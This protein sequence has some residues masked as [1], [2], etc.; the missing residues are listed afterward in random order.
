MLPCITPSSDPASMRARARQTG[1]S[2]RELKLARAA[3]ERHEGE[4]TCNGR[5]RQPR[6][7]RCRHARLALPTRPCGKPK[8]SLPRRAPVLAARLQP[9][10]GDRRPSPLFLFMLRFLNADSSGGKKKATDG[11][12][13]VQHETA[14]VGI[15]G[16]MLEFPIN[17]CPFY[18]GIPYQNV[19]WFSSSGFNSTG[20][21]SKRFLRLSAAPWRV[22][23]VLYQMCNPA[24]ERSNR[25]MG[26]GV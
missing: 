15:M 6:G 1:A 5:Q 7:L 8:Y 13:R 20:F 16:H 2:A 25:G 19:L 10:S 3:A 12:G 11:D 18:V 22:W 4:G 23:R 14:L 17:V 9:R 26:R 24:S 21:R